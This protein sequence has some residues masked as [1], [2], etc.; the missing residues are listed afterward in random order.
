MDGSRRQ[1][2]LSLMES[3]GWIDMRMLIIILSDTLIRQDTCALKTLEK[4]EVVV[5]NKFIVSFMRITQ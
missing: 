2:A 5:S 3:R 4:V 1:I